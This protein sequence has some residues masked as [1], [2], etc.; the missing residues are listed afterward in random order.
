MVRNMSKKE[1][2][3]PEKTVHVVVSPADARM[4]AERRVDDSSSRLRFQHE[5][6]VEGF[7]TLVLING[8]AII[9]LLTY[10]GN[11][12]GLAEGFGGAFIAYAAALVASVLAYLFAYNSQAEL[13]NGDVMEAYRL[14]GVP[15]AEKK[16]QKDFEDRGMIWV[17]LGILFSV[18]ALVGFIAG[19]WLAMRAI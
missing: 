10:A 16:T 3:E 18:L 4:L 8:G 13:M 19:S 17:R 11:K 14:L 12:G 9:G 1:I 7:K 2:V 15:P 5:F 6:A